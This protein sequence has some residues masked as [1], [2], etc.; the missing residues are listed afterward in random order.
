MPA[1]AA[2]AVGSMEVT[3][4]GAAE[5]FL[6]STDVT[7]NRAK[8][9]SQ[10]LGTRLQPKPSRTVTASRRVYR[11]GTPSPRSLALFAPAIP[12]VT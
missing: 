8:I 12:L 9:P 11:A 7:P 4:P 6:T 5:T 1:E 3:D 10:V 2:V